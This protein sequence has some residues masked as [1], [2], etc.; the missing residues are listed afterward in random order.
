LPILAS[1]GLCEPPAADGSRNSRR[2]AATVNPLI[3]PTTPSGKSSGVALPTAKKHNHS[4]GDHL[5]QDDDGHPRH[6]RSR[7]LGELVPNSGKGADR[8][9][10]FQVQLRRLWFSLQLNADGTYATADRGKGKT[11]RSDT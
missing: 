9:D 4:S 10:V 8:Y 2:V 1:G 6:N 7:T 11:I 5:I 3:A